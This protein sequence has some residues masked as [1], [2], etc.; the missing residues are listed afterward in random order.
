MKTSLA[1]PSRRSLA[2]AGLAV[3]ATLAL[4]G[5][6]ALAADESVSISSFAFSPATVTITAGDTVTWTNADPVG[7]TATATDASWDT[8]D[9]AEGA[10]ASI[11]FSTPGTYTY[12]CTPHPT[13]TG[14]VVVQAAAGGGGGGGGAT[15]PPTDTS[16][17]S[18]VVSGEGNVGLPALLLA[19]GLVAGGLLVVG[20]RRL[21]AERDSGS[22]NTR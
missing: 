16:A 17:A 7:H 22:T 11:T 9:I 6:A 15:L 19:G 21:T 12:L 4:G 14:T 1:R 8:G 20:R 18:V 13:M 5:P 3:A 2:A 10:S